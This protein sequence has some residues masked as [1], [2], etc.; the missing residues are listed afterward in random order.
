VRLGDP[1][2]LRSIYREQVRWTFPHRYVG[3][4]DGRTGIYCQPGNRGKLIKRAAGENYLD[5]W[6]TDSPP[7]DWTWQRTH[8][9][10]FMRAGDAHTVEVTWDEEWNLLGWY[11]NLQAPLVVNGSF[12]DTT[13]WA[14][15]VTVEPN[16]RWAWKDEADFAQA[17]ELGVFAGID[18]AV[19][20]AEGKRV[21]AERPWPTG[22][23]TWRP[24]ARWAP[25]PLPGNWDV[26]WRRADHA[27]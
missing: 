8:R 7:F 18:P 14:L 23:E 3:E 6:V 21:I 24:P 27:P 11:V 17:I 20:R 9:L 2:L 1:V 26:V 12:F 22:W 4:W 5:T 25:L 15:D 19:V 16:G 10:A 13:D